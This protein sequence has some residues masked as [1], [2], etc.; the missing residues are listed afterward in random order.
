MPVSPAV[1]GR[2]P[3]LVA[4]RT[5][6]PAAGKRVRHDVRVPSPSVLSVNI[7]LPRDEEW[8]GN[9]RRTAIEKRSVTD[10]VAVRTLGMDGDE[11]AD[12]V[13]H[14]GIDKAVYAFAREDLDHWGA[15]L[16]RHLPPGLFGENL[17]TVGIDVNEAEV[18]ERWRIG[19]AL[20]EVTE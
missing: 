1:P 16:G 6:S 19:T 2:L 14:G 4:P 9:L 7:G 10:P 3:V 13:N 17:T 12:K 20:L 15:Q 18:G 5:N 8:A 11:V